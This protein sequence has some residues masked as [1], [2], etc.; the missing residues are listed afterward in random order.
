MQTLLTLVAMAGDFY[1]EGQ[2]S[3][4]TVYFYV[5]IINSVAQGVALYALILFYY[6]TRHEL[7]PIRPLA[8]VT[9]G[10]RSLFCDAMRVRIA[11]VAVRT[12][13]ALSGLCRGPRCPSAF[14]VL[15]FLPTS[16]PLRL[17]TRSSSA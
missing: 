1:G 13:G 8:K 17:P 5:A 3:P 2:L 12:I 7:A 6:T 9:R 14:S 10:Q 11:A 15:S 16:P 4:R